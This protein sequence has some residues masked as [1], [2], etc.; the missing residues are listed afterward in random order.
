M[1][2]RSL[3]DLEQQIKAL[4]AEAEE[5][6]LSEGIEQLRIVIRKYKVGLS[7]FNDQRSFRGDD[8]LSEGPARPASPGAASVQC[9]S[10]ALSR[11]RRDHRHAT[12]RP[13]A[14][15]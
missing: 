7:H 13:R 4:Q 11:R 12:R 1:V 9:P 14:R 5:L 3:E 6:R 10:S 15:R 2:S 8:R